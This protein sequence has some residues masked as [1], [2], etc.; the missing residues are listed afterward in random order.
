MRLVHADQGQ[1]DLRGA[2]ALLL[3]PARSVVTH[4]AIIAREVWEVLANDKKPR[5]RSYLA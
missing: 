2:D 4:H 3:E 5:S 1:A